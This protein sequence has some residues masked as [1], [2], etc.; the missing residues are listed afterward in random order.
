MPGG[1]NE[2][3]HVVLDSDNVVSGKVDEE[4]PCPSKI[5]NDRRYSGT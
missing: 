3:Q 2:I 5:S 1:E 4:I